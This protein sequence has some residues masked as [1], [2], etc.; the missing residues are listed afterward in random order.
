MLSEATVQITNS[1][2]SVERNA[3]RQV[4]SVE[5][6]AEL[7]RRARDIGEIT[8]TVSRISDQTNLLALNAAIE[9]ARAGDHG[10]GFAVVADEVRALA[11]SSDRSAQ[12]VQGLAGGIEADVQ[13]IVAAVRTAA[14]AAASEAQACAVVIETLDAI[15][16]DM[17]R[18]AEGSQDT[19]T[20]AVQAERAAGEAQ[21]G[22]EQV[23]SAAEEQSAAAAQAQ[24]AIRQQAQSLD[25]AQV[26]AQALAVL[27]EDLRT[28]NADGSAAEQFGATAEELSATVQELSS[29]ATEIMAAVEQINRGSQQQASATQQTHAAL[30]QIETSARL[31]QKNASVADERVQ[32]MEGALSDS[33]ASIERLVSGLSTSLDGTRSSLATITRLES[34]GRKIEKIVDAIALV[35]V[36]TSML[37]VSG[38]VEA[39]RAGSSG[40]GFAVVS[41]DI[42]NLARE[43]SE[44]VE[45]VKETVRGIID[46]IASV[47][48]DIEQIIAS[49]EIEVRNNQAVFEV[50]DRVKGEVGSVSAANTAILQG[51]EFDPG[52][53]RR[54]RGRCAPDRGGRRRGERRLASGGKRLRTAGARSGG[55]G[56]RNRGD[57]VPGGRA[58]AAE[59]L[60]RIRPRRTCMP[61]RVASSPSGR[62]ASSTPSRRRTCPRSSSFRPSRACRKPPRAFWEWPIS[63]GPSCRW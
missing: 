42:R 9:A 34:V 56:R 63:A 24:S 17:T 20:A 32:L 57:R 8:R 47:R 30:T 6:I 54:D 11:E 45:T 41:S 22:A 2:R 58:E 7:E 53:Q 31:A 44:S 43:A 18:M 27:T 13:G 38:S 16:A 21:R 26:A 33:R 62:A 39:A 23:A 51:A 4:A 37:A 1:V 15:R 50:L 36:Q 60:S 40:R 10:R 52:G 28:G 46:Q 61:Q 29:A 59:W 25:Q 55:P 35:V 5:V 3:A 12:E 49:A 48:R 14:Q 19:M